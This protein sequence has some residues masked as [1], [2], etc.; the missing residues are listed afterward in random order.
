[1]Y[2]SLDSKLLETHACDGL[3]RGVQNVK[4][5]YC[6]SIK[7]GCSPAP[8]TKRYSWGRKG[9]KVLQGTKVLTSTCQHQAS[10]SSKLILRRQRK[11]PAGLNV[12]SDQNSTS[13]RT[14]IMLVSAPL[15]LK[16][17]ADNK[18]VASLLLAIGVNIATQF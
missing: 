4:R 10:S 7:V 16:R 5:R 15:R 2:T 9:T 13:M 11:C 1:M 6:E 8:M 3:S 12:S 14:P 17:L 18:T